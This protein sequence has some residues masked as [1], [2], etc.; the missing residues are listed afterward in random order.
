[1]P[2]TVA[3]AVAAVA[4]GR[5]GSRCALLKQAHY[6]VAVRCGRRASAEL[7]LSCVP[8]TTHRLRRGSCADRKLC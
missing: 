1:M 8:F 3:A 4:L 5:D 2:V 7:E 6:N